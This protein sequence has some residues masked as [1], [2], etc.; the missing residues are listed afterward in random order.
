MGSKMM[1]VVIQI[2]N[3]GDVVVLHT[4]LLACHLYSRLV[5][6]RQKPAV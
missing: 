3:S 4:E 1:Q 2:K 6:Q 5:E